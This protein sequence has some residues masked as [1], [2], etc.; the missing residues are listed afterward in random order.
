MSTQAFGSADRENDL[1]EFKIQ[2][3]AEALDVIDLNT[4]IRSSSDFRHYRQLSASNNSPLSLLSSEGLQAFSDSLVFRSGGLA[5]WR[6]DVLVNE[7]SDQQIY[8]VLQLFGRHYHA[9][10]VDKALLSKEEQLL[11]TATKFL[12]VGGGVR[13]NHACAMECVHMEHSTCDPVWCTPPGPEPMPLPPPPELPPCPPVS[14]WGGAW[15]S[16]GWGGWCR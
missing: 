7:L 5:S 2:V 8:Q 10:H 1:S 16:I 13:E 3:A 15:G 11:R 12:Y 9:P 14:P 6:H 4:T